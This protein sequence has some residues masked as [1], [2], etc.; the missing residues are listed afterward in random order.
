MFI[1]ESVLFLVLS[2]TAKAVGTAKA[3]KAE[4]TLFTVLAVLTIVRSITVHTVDTLR[5]PFTAKAECKTTTT[6]AL[7]TIPSVINILTVESAERVVTVFGFYCGITVVT[8]FTHHVLEVVPGFFE[9]EPLKVLGKWH[10]HV[11]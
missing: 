2:N 9:E 5:A 11:V 6:C 10:G 3:V 8:V 1:K 7:A 4:C